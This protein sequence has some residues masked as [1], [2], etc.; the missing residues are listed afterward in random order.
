MSIQ[1]SSYHIN[2]KTSANEVSNQ[3]HFQTLT[4]QVHQVGVGIVYGEH[5]AIAGVKLHHRDG[6]LH[7]PRGSQ[8]VLPLG[9]LGEAGGEDEAVL[10]EDA[11]GPLAALVGGGLLKT[12]LIH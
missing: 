7:V 11:P 6:V 9:A 2:N 5:D 1:E 12:R 3:V 8:G 10:Q 4:T